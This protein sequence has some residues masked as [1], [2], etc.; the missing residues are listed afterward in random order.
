MKKQIERRVFLKG[1]LSLSAFVT[2]SFLSFN[3]NR[4]FKSGKIGLTEAQ[5]MSTTGKGMKKI[6]VE[7]HCYTKEYVDWLYSSRT[8]F[9]G[10][11][12]DDPVVQRTIDRGEGRL[13]EMDEGGI[14]M[15]ILSLSYPDLDPFNTADAIALSRIVNDELAETVKRNPDRF[16]AYCCLP[17]QDPEAAA[18]E[19]ER[20]V[21]RLGL[22][23]AMVNTI[24][25]RW[26]ADEKYEVLYERLSKLNVP[27]YLHQT[28][29]GEHII[30]DM[31]NLIG[32][33]FLDKYPNLHFMLGHAGEALPF[34]LWRRSRSQS[35]DGKRS[36]RQ[37]FIEHFSV[38][39]SDQCWPELLQFLIAVMGSDRILFGTD[40][41]YESSRQHVDFIDSAPINR[42]DRANICYRN[43]ERVFKL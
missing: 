9:K 21:T 15:Q 20:S 39:T 28:E 30:P 27:I 24:D 6:A 11:E 5:S 13:K 14:D 8:T 29:S 32:G 25:E 22:R 37:K 35:V 23:G 4:S 40:Y 26:M 2:G 10:R 31:I 7:E 18:D 42:K 3:K 1:L 19:L 33:D 38:T 16:A 36:F 41:P 34:W 43:A 12:L 17:L